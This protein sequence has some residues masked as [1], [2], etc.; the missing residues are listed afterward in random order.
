[1]AASTDSRTQVAE[2][3]TVALV[4]KVAAELQRLQ[5]RTSMSKT[6]LTNRAITLYEFIDAEIQA[7][8]EVLIRDG[9]TGETQ[10]LRFL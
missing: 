1:M 5:E 7:G 9:K 3:I 10:L 6:D 2:R 4:P 8:R